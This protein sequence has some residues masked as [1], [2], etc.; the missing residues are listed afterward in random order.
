MSWITMEQGVRFPT[1]ANDFSPFHSI[2]IGFE[3]QTAFYAGYFPGIKSA[4]A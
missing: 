3:D 2:Q 1:G 4:G